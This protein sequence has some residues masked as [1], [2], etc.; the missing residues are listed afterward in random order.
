[1][2]LFARHAKTSLE[3]GHELFEQLDVLGFLAGEPEKRA[4]AV[5]VAAKRG[6]A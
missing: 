4:N 6:R 3:L 2:V 1:M 5:V